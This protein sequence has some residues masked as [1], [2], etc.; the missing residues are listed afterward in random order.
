MGGLAQ[1]L[2]ERDDDIDDYGL[3]IV[4]LKRALRGAAFAAGALQLLRSAV[5]TGQFGELKRRLG[6]LK[7]SIFDEL[8]RQRSEY[9]PAEPLG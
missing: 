5:S 8:T 6:E 7:D 1:A 4:Q 2:S 3:R 9:G